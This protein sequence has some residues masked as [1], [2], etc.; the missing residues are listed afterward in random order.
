VTPISFSAFPAKAGN[1]HQGLRSPGRKLL[2]ARFRGQG[3]ILDVVS[4]R[5]LYAP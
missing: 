4:L 3:E 2:D 1:Q 5:N